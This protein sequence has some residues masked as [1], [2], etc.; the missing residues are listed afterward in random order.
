MAKINF[1]AIAKTFGRGL[2][3]RSPEI[4]VG[5]GIVGMIGA[6]IMAVKATPKALERIKDAERDK[7]EPLTPKDTFKVTWRNYVPAV[8]T[9]TLSAACI[10]GANS[11]HLRRKAAL[12]AAC[13]LSETALA[14]FKSHAIERIGEKKVREI[15]DDVAKGE[16]KENP[17]SQTPVVVAS[18]GST[19]CYDPFGGRYFWGDI[20][21]IRRAENLINKEMLSQGYV[22][23]NDFYYEIGQPE[24][25]TGNDLGWNMVNG[26]VELWLSSQLDENDRPCAVIGF[27]REPHYDFQ[28]K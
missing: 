19:W 21:K 11:I 22:S 8:V 17:A 26:F 12:S 10:V 28:S 1:S 13:A 6:A 24:T 14:N 9:G 16:I 3:E 23:L 20:E 5:I 27:R 4:L 18:S 25:K 15:A 7:K 2:K